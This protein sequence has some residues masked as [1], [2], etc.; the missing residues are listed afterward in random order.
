MKPTATAVFTMHNYIDT[1]IL[2]KNKHTLLKISNF[3]RVL[4]SYIIKYNNHMIKIQQPYVL[5]LLESTRSCFQIQGTKMQVRIINLIGTHV[6]I[7]TYDRRMRFIWKLHTTSQCIYKR[8]ARGSVL[9]GKL[10]ILQ[11]STRFNSL[12]LGQL[13]EY[14]WNKPGNYTNS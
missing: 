10:P 2:G 3:P 11:I 14:L 5:P 12:V 7:C 9:S 4:A 6:C 1:N 8:V 13:Y